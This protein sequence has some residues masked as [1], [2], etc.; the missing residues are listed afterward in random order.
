MPSHTPPHNRATMKPIL[1]LAQ[2]ENW[3]H[4]HHIDYTGW[5][6]GRAKTTAQLLQ[7]LQRGETT[8]ATNP[9]RRIV[10]TVMIIIRR[11]NH[12]LLETEQIMADG[13]RRYR[14]LPPSEKIQAGETYQQAAQR[15]LCEELGRQPHQIQLH[16]ATYR[17]TQRTQD[18]DSYPNLLANYHIHIIEATVANLPQ[19]PF[20]TQEQLPHGRQ[21]HRWAWQPIPPPIAEMLV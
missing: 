4:Q 2:L 11:G 10:H 8:L 7:E 14:T 13:R 9:P 6:Y 1:T 16:P 15:G 18:S 20:T 17:Q 19:H 21:T 12:I 5:G 3:L